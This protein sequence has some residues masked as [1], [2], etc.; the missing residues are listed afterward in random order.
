MIEFD[1]DVR[2]KRLDGGDFIFDT[3][4]GCRYLNNIDELID[5]IKIWFETKR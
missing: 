2:I 4:L 3:D 5:C 1:E